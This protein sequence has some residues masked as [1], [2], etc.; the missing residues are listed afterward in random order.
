[1][2]YALQGKG[3]LSGFK[4]YSKNNVREMAKMVNSRRAK[5]LL[6]GQGHGTKCRRGNNALWSAVDE[7]RAGV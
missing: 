1:V 5:I 4:I 7:G 3:S 6:N 2:Q